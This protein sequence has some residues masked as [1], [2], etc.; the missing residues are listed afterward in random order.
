MATT[1][2]W[3][4]KAGG[5]LIGRLWVPQQMGVILMKPSFVPGLD[6]Q[7]RYADVSAQELAAGGTYVVGGKEILNR[8][9]SYD[10]TGDETNLLGDDVQ[11]GP[12][13]L[14]TTHYGI[15]YEM[16]TTDKYLWEILDFGADI[17][18]SG[19]FTVDF[20]AGILSVKAAP[21]V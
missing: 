17:T 3:F 11:W 2:Q 6:V 16:A 18:V 19:Y 21:A 5:N 15:V 13:A 8:A 1:A 7:M 4:P 12:G 20:L 10:P 9:V 14:F